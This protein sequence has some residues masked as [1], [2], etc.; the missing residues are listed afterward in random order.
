MENYMNLSEEFALNLFQFEFSRNNPC[1][2]Y[3]LNLWET[4]PTILYKKNEF[5]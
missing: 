3:E 4:L 2:K 5:I 1:F